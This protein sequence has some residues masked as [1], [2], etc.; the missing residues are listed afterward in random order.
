MATKIKIASKPVH[1]QSLAERV[2]PYLDEIAKR[3]A[4]TEKARM[5]PVENIDIIREAGFMRALV[6][7]AW[8]G[9]ERDL[10]DFSE[11]VRA[12]ATACPSTGWVTGVLNIHQSGISLFDVS[13]QEEVW[14]STPDT[15]ISS[16]GT[17]VM[18]AKVVEGGV[19]VSGRGRWSSGCDHAEWA[20]VGIKVPDPSD[21]EYPERRH[22]QYMSM[23]HRS[24]FVIDDTWYSTGMRGS[25]SKDLVFDN[26]FVPWRRMERLDAL[27]FGY[28]RGDGTVDSWIAR[29]PFSL[30]FPTFLPAVALGCADGMLREYTKRQRSR[31][32][33]LS[34]AYGILNPAGYMRLSESVHELE[35]ISVYYKHLVDSVQAYGER[36]EKLTESKFFDMLGKFPFVTDRATQ[37][38]DRLFHGAGASAIADFNPMQRY[39]RDGHTVRLHLGSDY[40][41]NSQ[42]HGRSLIGLPPTPDI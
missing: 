22:R 31:K 38:I 18:K 13:V 2:A 30:I 35:S 14:G 4:A 20:M 3:A 42:H 26:A 24:Q 11:G 25:G 33:L 8:G 27:N 6:P 12:V 40:D 41:T 39:W 10:S 17:P 1:R 28:S 7:A 5:V 23:M 15:I 34:D 37:V 19:V 16:S 32:N 21:S 9:D 36:G 29:V